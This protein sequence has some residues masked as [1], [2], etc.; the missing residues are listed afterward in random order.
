MV[1][2]C[3]FIFVSH[4]EI[5][6]YSF[7]PL[8]MNSFI[9]FFFFFFFVQMIISSILSSDYTNSQSHQQHINIPNA[10]LFCQHLISSNFKN[11]CQLDYYETEFHCDPNLFFSSLLAKWNIISYVYWLPLW[12]AYAL[13]F[14]LTVFK[15]LSIYYGYV[16][17]ILSEIYMNIKIKYFF[18]FSGPLSTSV[19]CFNENNFT[20]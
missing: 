19:M 15:G 17:S 3:D 14:F 4:C 5:Y 1:S 12:L 11:F 8:W 6:L 13:C 2:I 10:S 18:Q 20:F 9:H 16:F 7:F